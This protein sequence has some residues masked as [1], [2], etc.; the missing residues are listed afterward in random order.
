[1]TASTLR[2]AERGPGPGAAVAVLLLFGAL[3]GI[4]I[5]VGEAEAM[6][7]AVAAV[8]CLAALVDFRAGALFL[9][10]M[11]PIGAVSFF[12]HSM[13]GFTGLNP[14][15]VLVAFTLVSFLFRGQRLGMLAP[16][17]LLLLYVAPIVVA[18]LIGSRHVDDI[19]SYFWENELLHF[20]DGTGYLRD[21]MLKPLVIVVAALL[22]GAAVAQ[23]KKPERF[24]AP[25]VIAVWLMSLTAIGFV[26]DSGVRLGELAS[27]GGRAFFSS[28]GMHA[29]D[30]GRLYAVAYALLLFTWGETKD[31]ALKT[32]LLVTMGVLTIA[33]LLTFSR[34]A[35]IGFAMIN[36]LF[37]LWKFNARTAALAVLALTVG[38][39]LLPG[40]VVGRMM[41][42][43]DDGGSM[44]TVSAGRVDDIWL[45]L[46]PELW[47]SPLWGNG[48]DS[49]MWSDA[50]WAGTILLVGHP[51]NAYLQA[52]LDMGVLGLGLLLGYFVHV[53]RGFRSLGSNAY[54]SPAMRGFFQGATAGLLCFLLTGFAGSSLRPTAEFAFLWI[55][56]GMMYGVRAR[57]PE[58]T[59]TGAAQPKL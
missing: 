19:V 17:P 59:A 10:V 37:L 14:I 51:H 11:L 38:A 24:L 34:G 55:A 56:I 30:L 23:S 32:V 46:L 49:I 54:L 42:G 52:L 13:F 57:T 15:N 1:M 16:K 40:A 26:L 44:N 48:L 4:G 6:I 20:S 21:M 2:Y 3:A 25:I 31:R 33:L 58:K 27:T 36:G 5:A 41:L 45:P 28:L 53:W 9:M 29:N 8:A 12:P 18:G 47:R 50:A 39:L 43:F 35:F 22:V 7:A